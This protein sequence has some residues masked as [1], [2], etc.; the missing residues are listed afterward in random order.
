[1]PGAWSHGIGERHAVLRSGMV[2]T[3]S[4]DPEAMRILSIDPGAST[5]W[6]VVERDHLRGPKI[7]ASGQCS[8]H[9]L[10]PVRDLVRGLGITGGVCEVPR[11][12]PGRGKADPDDIVTLSVRLGV[13]IGFLGPEV[14]GTWTWRGVH[15]MAWKGQVPKPIHHARLRAQYPDVARVQV[16]DSETDRLDAIGLGLW[17][18]AQ[19]RAVESLTFLIPSP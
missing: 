9:S 12:Y 19:G 18:L 5:G 8:I 13:A 11:I 1:M 17:Y 4:R 14:Q 10:R 3:S 16:P 2:G 15:P 6:A 7:L